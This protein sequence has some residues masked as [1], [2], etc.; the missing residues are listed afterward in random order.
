MN[1]LLY[2]IEEY[3]IKKEINKIKEKEKISDDDIEYYDMNDIDL[4]NILQDILTISLFSNKRMIVIENSYIFTGTTGK[5][6][7]DLKNLEKYLESAITDN[8]LIFVTISEKLDQRK[9]IVSLIKEKGT[10]KEFNKDYN[11]N[12]IILEMF[13][14]YK[15]SNASIELLINRVGTDLNLLEREI[16][17]IKTYKNDDYNIT[18]DDIKLITI[19]TIDT[20]IFHL[21]ENI[22]LK[23]KQKALESYYEMIKYGEEPIKIIVML[24]NQFRLIYQVKKLK[25]QRH[26]IFD[27]MNILN[28]KKY[29]IEKALSKSNQF[30]EDILLD[31][32][33]K[34]ADLDINIKSGKIDKNIGLELFILQN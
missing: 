1:Y 2:G 5:K 21:I 3:L 18:D 19:K 33:Y 25:E 23:N 20:D 16:E 29:P 31:Y 9:K 34:L 22:V 11:L 4:N 32:L 6:T 24:A 17:K 30:T 27:M 15:I 13:D 28:Q 14:N 12:K 7:Q 26:S 8:I 10:V